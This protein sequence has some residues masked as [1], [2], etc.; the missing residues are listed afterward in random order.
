MV[1]F[2]QGQLLTSRSHWAE[3]HK[4]K[5]LNASRETDPAVAQQ[6]FHEV[7]PG[8]RLGRIISVLPGFPVPFRAA[9]D[10]G[11]PEKSARERKPQGCANVRWNDP[12]AG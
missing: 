2:L 1:A 7:S 3:V 6:A 5:N 4:I 10:L 12:P 9:W 8:F 11:E